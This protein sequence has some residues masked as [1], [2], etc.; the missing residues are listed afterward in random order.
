MRIGGARPNVPYDADQTPRKYSTFYWDFVRDKFLANLRGDY[1]IFVTADTESVEQE[2]IKEFGNEKAIVIP[3][4]SAHVDRE[5]DKRED[6]SRYEKIVMDFWMLGYCDK[7]LVSDSGF[8]IFGVLNT[9]IPG[10]DFY[11]LTARVA[12]SSSEKPDIVDLNE[13]I[14]TH[15]YRY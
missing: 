6:C 11:L 15:P 8:G 9:K 7:A 1:R 12:N 14:H 5:S 10:K 4:I 2:S 3:G 13:Y